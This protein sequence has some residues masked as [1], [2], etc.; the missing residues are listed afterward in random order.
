M[1]NDQKEGLP[2]LGIGEGTI[3]RRAIIDKNARLETGRD[4]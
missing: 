3:V 1:R 4:Y 2:R